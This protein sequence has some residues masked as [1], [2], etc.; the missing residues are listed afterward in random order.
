MDRWYF[1]K[2]LLRD[3]DGWTL[4]IVPYTLSADESDIENGKLMAKAPELL[5]AVLASIAFLEMASNPPTELLDQ[6]KRAVE[7]ES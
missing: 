3:K 4:A 2:G 1:D 7:Y 5:A 6:L